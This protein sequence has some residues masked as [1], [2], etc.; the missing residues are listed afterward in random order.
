MRGGADLVI[1]QKIGEQAKLQEQRFSNRFHNPTPAYSN[2]LRPTPA[3]ID[4]KLEL[5]LE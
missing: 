5:W 4:A 1:N 3:K 2:S